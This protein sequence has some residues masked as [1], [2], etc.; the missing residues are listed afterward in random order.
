MEIAEDIK[1]REEEYASIKTLS[2]LDD[3]LFDKA[4]VEYINRLTK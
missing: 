2:G 3:G 4:Y 1:K